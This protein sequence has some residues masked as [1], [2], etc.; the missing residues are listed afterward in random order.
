MAA[1]IPNQILNLLQENDLN[2][3]EAKGLTRQELAED[4]FGNTKPKNVKRIMNNIHPAQVLA[5]NNNMMIIPIR[6]VH[7]IFAFCL[8]NSTK[9]SL[10]HW[11][12][13]EKRYR[14]IRIN[15]KQ[16]M[17]QRVIEFGRNNHLLNGHD[18]N[19]LE[20]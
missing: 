11:Y 19:S 5:L 2:D 20:S 8:F 16:N 10:R 7:K 1:S 18:P 12:Y 4:I 3:A 17:Y 6:P 14:E 15:G 13:R 9:E